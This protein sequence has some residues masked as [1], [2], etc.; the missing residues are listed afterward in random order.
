VYQY[1]DVYY[2]DT[3]M[4]RLSVIDASTRRCVDASQKRSP[5]A[6][7]A[8][9]RKKA[10]HRRATVYD[11]MSAVAAPTAAFSEDIDWR[12]PCAPRD[13]KRAALAGTVRQKK[14]K[15]TRESNR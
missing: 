2:R 11:A 15:S 1:H 3:D 14:S 5:H 13:A 8:L 4:T 6:S 9:A 10:P 12:K 7:P